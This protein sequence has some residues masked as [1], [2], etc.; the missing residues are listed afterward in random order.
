MHKTRNSKSIS[1]A[2]PV[3][4]VVNM[5]PGGMRSVDLTSELDRA[6]RVAR[7]D[8]RQYNNNAELTRKIHY[9]NMQIKDHSFYNK[10]DALWNE[11]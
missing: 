7:E 11:P 3:L 6:M 4:D 8:I 1:V 5:Q 10:T 9:S 2:D